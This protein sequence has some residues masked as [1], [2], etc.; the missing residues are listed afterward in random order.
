M[1]QNGDIYVSEFETCCPLEESNVEISMTIKYLYVETL[2]AN[3]GN[4]FRPG[5]SK[6]TFS[7]S[8]G[9][10]CKLQN[11]FRNRHAV[12]PLFKS[13]PEFLGLDDI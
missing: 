4:P 5:F 9:N 2:G 10:L 8:R 6:D 3:V 11:E 13:E 7:C 12:C 1:P